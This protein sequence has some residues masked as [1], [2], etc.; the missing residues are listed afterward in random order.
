M[1][2]VTAEETSKYSVIANDSTSLLLCLHSTIS[3]VTA[4]GTTDG[5]ANGTETD[6]YAVDA[7]GHAELASIALTIDG[8]ALT[9]H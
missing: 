3:G 1:T 8:T 5:L 4:Q 9:F 2:S 7:S 6:C